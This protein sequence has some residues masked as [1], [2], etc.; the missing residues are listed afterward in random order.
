MQIQ[1]K[2]SQLFWLA[3]SPAF[4]FKLWNIMHKI[5]CEQLFKYSVA[6]EVLQFFG[7]ATEHMKC[8]R[9]KITFKHYFQKLLLLKLFAFLRRVLFTLKVHR[10]PNTLLDTKLKQ[11]QGNEFF[12]LK[13]SVLILTF[14]HNTLMLRALYTFVR[15]ASKVCTVNGD[16]RIRIAY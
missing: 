12:F 16:P 8:Y 11:M 9:L 15:C 13:K 5:L 1:E 6:K 7:R 14:F 3:S 2:A 10:T 4:C